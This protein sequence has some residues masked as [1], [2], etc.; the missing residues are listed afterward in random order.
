MRKELHDFLISVD[1]KDN[2]YFPK[3]DKVTY[4]EI[5]E[6]MEKAK[7]LIEEKLKI[8]IDVDKS[9]QDASFTTDLGL[10]D[11]SWYDRKTRTGAL[12]YKFAFR[13]SNFGKMF[14]LHGNDFE[15]PEY[16][17]KN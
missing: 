11:E 8:K 10:L 6:K 12:V 2:W 13:F 1:E 3:N 4:E 9:V 7:R 15:A 17:C 5:W 16:R 14:T